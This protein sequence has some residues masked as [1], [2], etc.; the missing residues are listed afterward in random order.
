MH[1]S[2]AANNDFISFEIEPDRAFFRHTQSLASPLNMK[3]ADG[4]IPPQK[5]HRH[6]TGQKGNIPALKQ[7]PKPIWQVK[8]VANHIQFLMNSSELAPHTMN[9]GPK[10]PNSLKILFDRSMMLTPIFQL[11]RAK[12]EP[13]AYWL[14]TNRKRPH[15]QIAHLCRI[16]KR[17]GW[18]ADWQIIKECMPALTDNEFIEAQADH[19]IDI[20]AR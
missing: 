11:H 20:L 8:R 16:L 13:E 6:L 17:E 12:H 19:A 14:W 1:R 18:T 3:F 5:L 2:N 10:L 4:L 9:D 15:K 7:N